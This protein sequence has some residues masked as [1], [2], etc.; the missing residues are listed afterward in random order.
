MC[1]YYI[2]VYLTKQSGNSID[3]VFGSKEWYWVDFSFPE[4]FMNWSSIEQSFFSLCIIN[5]LPSCKKL[6]M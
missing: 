6:E 3:T 1:S 4:D 2:A 5:K